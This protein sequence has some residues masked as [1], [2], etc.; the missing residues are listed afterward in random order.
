MDEPTDANAI[1]GALEVVRQPRLNSSR[2]YLRS[3]L[4]TSLLISLPLC[5]KVSLKLGNLSQEVGNY[6]VN[7][8]WLLHHCIYIAPRMGG[9]ESTQAK[10][11][12][13]KTTTGQIQLPKLFVRSCLMFVN[14]KTQRK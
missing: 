1:H 14:I 5:I 13:I 9:T 4:S 7:V 6:L 12:G 10:P 11:T 2:Q 3:I 8:N